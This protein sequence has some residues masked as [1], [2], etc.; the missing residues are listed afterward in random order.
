MRMRAQLLLATLST[1]VLS[2]IVG[3][4]LLGSLAQK[5]EKSFLETE[6]RLGEH[7]LRRQIEL[8]RTTRG[9]AY[10]ALSH[11]P[12]L[13]KSL[14]SG[15]RSPLTAL[16]ASCRQA[17][18]DV[19]AVVDV[20]SNLLASDGPAA[21]QLAVEASRHAATESGSLFAVAGAVMDG[22]RIPLGADPP[23]GYLIAAKSATESDGP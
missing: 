11:Q 18:A 20:A 5:T 19:V 4:W 12:A 13:L 10:Q 7:G 8:R 2:G 6:L 21:A 23:L 17:G 1:A 9:A 16:V 3:I 22:F 15:D 14:A